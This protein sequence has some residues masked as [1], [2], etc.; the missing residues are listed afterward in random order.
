V[1]LENFE[2]SISVVSTH[3]WLVQYFSAVDAAVF[4]SSQRFR[5]P[6]FNAFK[7]TPSQIKVGCHQPGKT[8]AA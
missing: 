6:G 7:L 2:P 4:E 1:Q 8:A 5:K 3:G